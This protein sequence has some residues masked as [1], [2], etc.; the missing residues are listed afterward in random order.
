MLKYD[1][2]KAFQFYFQPRLGHL[3]S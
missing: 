3:F 1:I 2:S